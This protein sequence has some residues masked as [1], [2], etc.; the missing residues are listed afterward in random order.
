MFV[1][2]LRVPP[3]NTT[4][5]GV[6]RGVVDFFGCP[7]S[8]AMLYGGTSHAF[9]LGCVQSRLDCAEMTP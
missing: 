6:V 4:L 3:F 8:A 1:K 2:D 5:M 7:H 9:L